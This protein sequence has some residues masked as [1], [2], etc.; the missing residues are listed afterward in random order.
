MK[1]CTKIVLST[2]YKTEAD[3]EKL[4]QLSLKRLQ[5]SYIDLFLIHW[6]GNLLKC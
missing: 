6:P 3:Y 4:V 1:N 2:D 5:T